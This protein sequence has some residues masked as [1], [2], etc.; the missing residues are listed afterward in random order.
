MLKTEENGLW[1]FR[2]FS[3]ASRPSFGMRK[4]DSLPVN[5]QAKIILKLNIPVKVK[6]FTW[7]LVLC[8]VSVHTTLQKRHPYHS[9]SPDWC[10][11]CK[12]DNEA[13]DH[14]FL[15]CEFSSTIWCLKEIG[16]VWVIPKSSKELLC[17]RQG[18]FLNNKGKV[19]WKIASTTTFWAIWLERNNQIF[20]EKEKKL[21]SI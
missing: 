7:L 20:E 12:K 5:L 4:D 10:V 16:R 2:V 11:L 9:L 18:L 1:I 14:L 17:L 13:I 8:K 15:H 6:V 3:L 19:L 21:E